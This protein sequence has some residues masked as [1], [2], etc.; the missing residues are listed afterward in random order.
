VKRLKGKMERGERLWAMGDR[1]G[2]KKKQLA[3]EWRHLD[4]EGNTTYETIPVSLILE[5][6]NIFIQKE[7]E[8]HH[9]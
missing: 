5:A 4:V 9:V 1:D 3:I 2:E 6:A 7:T 8:T